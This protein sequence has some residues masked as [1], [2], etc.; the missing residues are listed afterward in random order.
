MN[1]IVFVALAILAAALINQCRKPAGWLGRYVCWSM[2]RR[3]SNVTDWGL[4]HVSIRKDD[5]ILDVGCGGG[6]TI[7][8]LSAV[9]TAG[10]VFGVDYSAASVAASRSANAEAISMGRVDV[11][12]ASVSELPFP[13]GMFDLVTAVET[14]Y[15]WP[16]LA[17]DMRGILRVLKPGG[18]LVIVA[19]AYRGRRFDAPFRVAMKLLRSSYLTVSQHRELFVA[20]GFSDVEIFEERGK[21]WICGVGRRPL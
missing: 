7:Q 6:R 16:N 9:A 14:H 4:Q 11:R 10:K 1:V 12:Q 15:Y 5:T 19:E 21:G 3:H 20:A 17:A 8:K 18:R 2:N 13:D